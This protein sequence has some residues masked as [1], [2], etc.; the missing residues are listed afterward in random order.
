MLALLALARK[1]PEEYEQL[2]ES[3][4]VLKALGG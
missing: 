4:A 3:E 2:R 1:H